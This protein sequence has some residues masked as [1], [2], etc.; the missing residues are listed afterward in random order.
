MKKFLSVTLAVIMIA[1]TFPFAFAA[2]KDT[3]I[4]YTNDVHCAIEDYAVLA[5]YRAELI[6]QGKNVITVSNTEESDPYCFVLNA[7]GDYVASGDDYN[8][9]LDF[10]L[11]CVFESGKTYS[12]CTEHGYL[13]GVYCNEC[14]EII[15]GHEEYSLDEGYHLDE[16]RDDICDLCGKENIWAEEECEHI[17]HSDHWFWSI[18]W[19]IANFFHR[20]FGVL[21]ECECGEAHYFYIDFDV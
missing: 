3:V 8:G 17:C 9:T 6:A 1:A 14:E 2:E 15:Y 19:R 20:V 10:R 12:N 18:V 13:E 16:N 4:L 5:A 21:P 11:V 7:D